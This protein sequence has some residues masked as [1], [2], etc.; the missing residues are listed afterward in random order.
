MY[1]RLIPTPQ[2]AED[3]HDPPAST[4]WDEGYKQPS[5]DYMVLGNRAF[6]ILEKDATSW[7]YAPAFTLVFFDV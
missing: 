1:P 2:A 5:S 6:C 4:C 7:T 3:N